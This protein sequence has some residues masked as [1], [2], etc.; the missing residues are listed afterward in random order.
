[1]NKKP[2][3]KKLNLRTWICLT[4]AYVFYHS[5]RRVILPTRQLTEMDK[6]S[7]A[8]VNSA[9]YKNVTYMCSAC[10]HTQVYRYAHGWERALSRIISHRESI[11][12]LK[13]AIKQE[14]SNPAATS[15]AAGILQLPEMSKADVAQ[16]VLITWRNWPRQYVSVVKVTFLIYSVKFQVFVLTP[17]VLFLSWKYCRI[18]QER[19]F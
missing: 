8:H 17:C 19:Y 4:D 7:S 14:E 10:I 1:M 6:E 9:N 3:D 15:I 12:V 18:F 5:T 13:S 16:A 11:D 2:T